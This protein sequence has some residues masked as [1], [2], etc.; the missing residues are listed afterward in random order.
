MQ[1][2]LPEFGHQLE[3]GDHQNLTQNNPPR[4]IL[5]QPHGIQIPKLL[6]LHHDDLELLFFSPSKSVVAAARGK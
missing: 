1:Q 2:Q 6:L 3:T 5:S 4:L